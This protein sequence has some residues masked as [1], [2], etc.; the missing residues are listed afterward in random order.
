MTTVSLMKYDEFVQGVTSEASLDTDV[1][2]ERIRKLQAT[3]ADVA[4]LL[5]GASGL[6]GES[7]EF[8][9]L[10]KK[11]MFQ[12]KDMT[13]D[14]RTHLLKELGDII[15]YWSTAVRALGG[16]PNDVIQANVTKL[17]ARYPGGFSIA[18]SEVR[19]AGD[20]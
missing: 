12:G 4:P 14:V 17:S 15:F 10:V 19:S 13:D 16:N 5:T 18:D 8:N 20:I 3:G 6:A 9:D 7:G 1:L 11:I 2:I